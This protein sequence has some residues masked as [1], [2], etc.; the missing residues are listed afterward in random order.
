MKTYFYTEDIHKGKK[1]R[2]TVRGTR[3]DDLTEVLHE[4]DI[5]VPDK[6]WNLMVEI[7]QSDKGE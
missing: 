5:E 6:I 3:W 2:V 4:V 7:T 1:V